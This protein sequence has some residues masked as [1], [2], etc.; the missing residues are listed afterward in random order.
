MRKPR[1]RAASSRLQAAINEDVRA[2]RNNDP[3]PDPP[4][5]TELTVSLGTSH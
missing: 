1:T 2:K 3:N 4:R 5:E